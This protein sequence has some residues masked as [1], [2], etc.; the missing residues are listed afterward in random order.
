VSVPNIKNEIATNKIN[1]HFT[2]AKK[3]RNHLRL[4]IG[5]KVKFFISKDGSVRMLPKSD[6]KNLKGTVRKPKKAFTV[7]EMKEALKREV[8]NKYAGN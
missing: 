8:I 4:Q 1:G 6:I 7:N 3:I 5:D 2:F